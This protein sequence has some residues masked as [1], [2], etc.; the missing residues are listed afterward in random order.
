MKNAESSSATNDEFLIVTDEERY[1]EVVANVSHKRSTSVWMLDFGCSYHVCSNMSVFD[2][3]E[4]KK[5]SKILLE[6]KTIYDVLGV[7]TMKIKIQ[8]VGVRSLSDVRHVTTL[9]RNLNSH[10]SLDI[11]G[12]A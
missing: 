6:D 7:G 10:G 1:E 8:D 2:A 3:Y 9:R 12:Y 4:E 11:E 5:G